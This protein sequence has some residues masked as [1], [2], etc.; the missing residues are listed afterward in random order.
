M[1]VISAAVTI[2]EIAGELRAELTKCINRDGEATLLDRCYLIIVEHAFS[3]EEI[4]ALWLS[5]SCLCDHRVPMFVAKHWAQKVTNID[6]W[7]EALKR[8]TTL[9]R[10][11]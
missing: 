5:V 1:R 4:V 11:N 10:N 8:H 6:D 2:T 3:D 7:M 9:P